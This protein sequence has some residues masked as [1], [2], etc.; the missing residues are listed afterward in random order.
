MYFLLFSRGSHR[1]SPVVKF[2]IR[3]REFKHED[4]WAVKGNGLSEVQSCSPCSL[5]LILGGMNCT[6]S[7]SR[8][9][10][11]FYPSRAAGRLYSANLQ[12]PP[13]DQ[14]SCSQPALQAR[15]L[16]GF[17][18]T[19]SSSIESWLHSCMSEQPFIIQN[20]QRRAALVESSVLI[21]FIFSRDWAGKGE[22][23]GIEA[24]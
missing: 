14:C 22:K 7:S 23:R 11:H 1:T 8:L 3:F 24:L 6:K 9:K 19:I 15:L 12:S 17:L 13:E 10:C 5:E 21:C 4:H 16:P 20:V 18:F 2:S